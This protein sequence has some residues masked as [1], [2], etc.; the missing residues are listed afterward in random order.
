M[1]LLYCIDKNYNEQC[2]TAIKSHVSNTKSPLSIYIIHQEPNTFSKEFV[3]SF[4]ENK[5]ELLEVIKFQE[6]LIRENSK[7]KKIIKNSH[8]SMATYFRLFIDKHLPTDLKQI[9]YLDPDVICLKNFEME[10]GE[11]FKLMK[12]DKYVISSRTIGDEKGNEET[13]Q[14]LGL[15]NRKY[16]NAGVMFIDLEL[17]R[18]ENIEKKLQKLLYKNTYKYHDQDILNTYFDG[19][20]LELYEHMNYLMDQEEVY[21]KIVIKYVEESA[22]L[23]HYI[24]ANKPWDTDSANSKYSSYYQNY[25]SQLG[26]KTKHVIKKPR[27]RNYKILVKFKNKKIS[28]LFK[29]T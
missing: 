16:F 10:Y 15:K 11:I 25:Y 2:Y 13:F 7:F 1:N 20:Y 9:V 4:S 23:I 22:K 14:R 18:Q 24:G 19:D 17:W 6:N 3:E 26:L 28:S 5:I 27:N 21:E 29:R 12:E 8:Y